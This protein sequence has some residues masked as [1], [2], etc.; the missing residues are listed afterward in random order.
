MV[1]RTPSPSLAFAALLFFAAFVLFASFR[2]NSALGSPLV[3]A[4]TG[5]AQMAIPSFKGP[6]MR[7]SRSMAMNSAA[8]DAP[9]RREA[10]ATGKGGRKTAHAKCAVFP[11][12]GKIVIND[13]EATD[14][15]KN[16]L[17]AYMELYQILYLLGMHTEHDFHF[18]VAGGGMTG[19]KDAIKLAAARLLLSDGFP[20]SSTL[21]KEQLKAMLKEKGMLTRD[22]RKKE[23]KKYGLKKARKAPQFSKR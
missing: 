23:R 16:N 5:P 14:Y 11:G 7:I 20:L 9:V 1:G 15:F 18:R 2:S 13:K 22:A 6:A 4:R 8:V 21:P 19:Q 10:I 12:S 3:S 17:V